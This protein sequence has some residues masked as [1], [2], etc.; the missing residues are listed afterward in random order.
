M[1][2][3]IDLDNAS[4]AEMTLAALVDELGED[5]ITQLV[6]LPHANIAPLEMVPIDWRDV[7]IQTETSTT[8]ATR[9]LL[10]W[11]GE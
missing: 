8:E 7:S 2:R 5:R 3:G 1:V 4:F 10:N 11:K 6:S 9:E